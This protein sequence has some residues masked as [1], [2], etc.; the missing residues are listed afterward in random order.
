MTG[1]PQ[2]RSAALNALLRRIADD[3]RFVGWAL[4]RVGSTD[5]VAVAAR[6]GCPPENLPRL[7]LCLRPNDA[8]NQFAAEVHKIATYVGCDAV[9]LRDL[10]REATAVERLHSPTDGVDVVRGLL[11]AARDRRRDEVPPQEDAKP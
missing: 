3:D 9:H 8:S 5:D 1:K 7:A 10:L 11:L 4:A 2:V 6:L